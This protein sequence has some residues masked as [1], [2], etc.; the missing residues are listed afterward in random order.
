MPATR[1]HSSDFNVAHVSAADYI[2][3]KK[4]APMRG[5]L[6]ILAIL[7]A[8]CAATGPQSTPLELEKLDPALQR[9]ILGTPAGPA[10]YDITPGPAGESKFGVI[11]RTENADALRSAG[12][13]VTSA[14]GDVAVVRVT[15]AQLRSL[16]TLPSVKN[17]TNGSKNHTM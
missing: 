3:C 2:D 5:L 10:E 6:F 14:F 17:V 11:V 8:G 7:L 13:A 1:G 9:L 15:I 16:V 12:Y 4:K